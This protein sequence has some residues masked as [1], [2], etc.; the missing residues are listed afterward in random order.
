MK[1]YKW[2]IYLR[3]IISQS[4]CGDG[5]TEIDALFS[6][7]WEGEMDYEKLNIKEEYE[8]ED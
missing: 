1:I 8:D 7:G 6:D 4:L 3:N 2:N 5:Q